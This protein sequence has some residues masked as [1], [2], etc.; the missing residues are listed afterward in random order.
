MPRSIDSDIQTEADAT[1]LWDRTPEQLKSYEKATQI[2]AKAEE[3]RWRLQKDRIVTWGAVVLLVAAFGACLVVIVV[4]HDT[5]EAQP[6]WAVLSSMVAG[7]FSYLAGKAA[8]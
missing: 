2:I 5:R 8:R 1:D 6:A 3:A 4:K 7:V